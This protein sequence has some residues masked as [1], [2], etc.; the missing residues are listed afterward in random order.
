L[1]IIGVRFQLIRAPNNSTPYPRW[2]ATAFGLAMTR[3]GLEARRNLRERHS[4]D[5][6]VVSGQPWMGGECAKRC[7]PRLGADAVCR[8]G[9]RD[10]D[11]I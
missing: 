5:S 6:P 2:I 4:Q 9:S 7:I 8:A 1:G 10:D 11:S 3:A